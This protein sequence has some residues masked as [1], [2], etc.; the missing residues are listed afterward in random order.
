M[1]AGTSCV[2]VADASKISRVHPGGNCSSPMMP[3]CGSFGYD[4][5][6]IVTLAAE[7][8]AA[9]TPCRL[10]NAPSE[11]RLDVVGPGWPVK[12]VRQRG[13]E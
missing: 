3:S 9:W 1:R 6:V 8:S 12:L 11:R 4:P 7:P 13:G 10:S 2:V 5:A